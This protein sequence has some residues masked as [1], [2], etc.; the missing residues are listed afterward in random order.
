MHVYP[1]AVKLKDMALL[2]LLTSCYNTFIYIIL[3]DIPDMFL[4]KA[5]IVTSGEVYS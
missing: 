3:P 5:A 1:L 2:S 4:M